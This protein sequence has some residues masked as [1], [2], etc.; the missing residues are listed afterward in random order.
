MR[1]TAVASQQSRALK[2]VKELDAFPKVPDNFKQTS[3]S[4][5]GGKLL[6]YLL[7]IYTLQW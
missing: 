5:G 7:K 1:R 2:A 6:Q 4:G 3:A